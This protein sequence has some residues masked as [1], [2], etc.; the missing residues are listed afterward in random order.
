MDI[1]INKRYA[2]QYHKLMIYLTLFILVHT[3]R[4]NV[5]IPN[6]FMEILKFKIN[7]F[8]FLKLF[9][10]ELYCIKSHFIILE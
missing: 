5:E 7:K 10:I 3:K 1:K 9:S 8:I 6:K 2:R 4:R